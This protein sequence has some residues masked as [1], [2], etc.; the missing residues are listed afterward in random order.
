[1]ASD[2]VLEFKEVLNEKLENASKNQLIE[3][4]EILT[5]ANRAVDD[6]DIARYF[7]VELE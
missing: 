5:E 6:E 3:L 1:M 7:G 4:I 2:G